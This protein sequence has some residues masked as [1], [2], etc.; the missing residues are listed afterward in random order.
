MAS[1]RPGAAVAQGA[2]AR[3][4]RFENFGIDLGQHAAVGQA[5]RQHA[6]RRPE[7]EDADENQRPDQFGNAAQDGEQAAGDRVQGWLFAPGAAGQI[8]QRHGDHK[9]QRHAGGGDG[10]RFQRRLGEIAEEL[11]PF[12]AAGSRTESCR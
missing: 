7:A 9:G 1:G 11:R 8:A 4:D 6:G 2:P 10:Q 5:Q 3:V 12:P